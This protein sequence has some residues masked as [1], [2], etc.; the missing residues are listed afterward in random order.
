MRLREGSGIS[1]RGRGGTGR[2]GHAHRLGED[3]GE[4]RRGAVAH[5]AGQLHGSGRDRREA[6]RAARGRNGAR[7][8]L[9]DRGGHRGL[10]DRGVVR[11]RTRRDRSRALLAAVAAVA[12][13]VVV[14]AA[15]QLG[16]L[17]V[18]GNVLVGHLLETSLEE[19]NFLFLVLEQSSNHT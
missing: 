6:V 2:Q 3:G 5:D 11:G 15:S 13:L 12:K 4:T 7:S 8:R 1:S 9:S 19:I 16:L 18:S 17:Q 14:Q 10:H